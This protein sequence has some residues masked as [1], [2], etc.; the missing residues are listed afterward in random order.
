M[1]IRIC[2]YTQFT[3]VSG[4]NCFTI[5]VRGYTP[6]LFYQ[7]KQVHIFMFYLKVGEYIFVLPHNQRSPTSLGQ[8]SDDHLSMMCDLDIQQWSSMVFIWQKPCGHIAEV[9]DVDMWQKLCN[10]FLGACKEPVGTHSEK[11]DI[12]YTQPCNIISLP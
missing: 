8:T 3:T 1:D 9:L 12:L 7:Q 5:K 11:Q 6:F 2:M 10:G 4:Y